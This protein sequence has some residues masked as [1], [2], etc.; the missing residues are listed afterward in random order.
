MCGELLKQVHHPQLRLTSRRDEMEVPSSPQ[1]FP[2]TRPTTRSGEFP[3][4]N[5]VPQETTPACHLALSVPSD[6]VAAMA[7]SL[8][9]LVLSV[10]EGKNTQPTFNEESEVSVS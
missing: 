10:G 9:E 7:G 3:R 4:V 5:W 1:L 6:G 8:P 2:Q